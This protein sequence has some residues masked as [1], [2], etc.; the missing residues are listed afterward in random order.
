MNL[1]G[2]MT[3]IGALAAAVLVAGCDRGAATEVG[4]VESP[5]PSPSTPVSPDRSA[6]GAS[7]DALAA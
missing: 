3:A 2:R 4:R 7:V 1:M 6:F 5:S